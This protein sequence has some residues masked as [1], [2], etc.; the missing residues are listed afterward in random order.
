M[1]YKIIWMS[2]A[3]GVQLN[4]KD[5]KIYYLPEKND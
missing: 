1:H 4:S 3:E 2:Y 5:E